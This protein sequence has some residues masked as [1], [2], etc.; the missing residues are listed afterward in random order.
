MVTWWCEAVCCTLNK[1]TTKTLKKQRAT[2]AAR[3]E[4]IR[5]GKRVS[6]VRKDH[7]LE[8][9]HFWVLITLPYLLTFSTTMWWEDLP[10]LPS[11]LYRWRNLHSLPLC[12]LKKKTTYFKIIL[13]YRKFAKVVESSYVLFSQ[14]Y[15]PKH[16]LFLLILAAKQGQAC[17]VLGWVS[18]DFH[19]G[20]TMLE[21]FKVLTPK[22]VLFNITPCSNIK[23]TMWI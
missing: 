2:L 13:T 7:C 22:P 21:R 12:H 16:S 19:Q 10:L 3:K 15:R 9:Q 11:P 8:E 20:K 4:K 14:S 18:V 6:Q 5:G 17:L 23:I 1:V